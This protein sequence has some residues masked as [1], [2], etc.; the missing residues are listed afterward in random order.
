MPKFD[1][2]LRGLEFGI[3][4]REKVN[5]ATEFMDTLDEMIDFNDLAKTDSMT[6]D[7]PENCSPDECKW[8]Q[9]VMFKGG[10]LDETS[11]ILGGIKHTIATTAS[12]RL[13]ESNRILNSFL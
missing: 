8:I 10:N 7:F 5:G 2:S 1:T 4:H 6:I 13:E 9:N 11:L 3:C 12:R